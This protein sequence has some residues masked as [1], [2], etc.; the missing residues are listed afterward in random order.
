MKPLIAIASVVLLI[1]VFAVWLKRQALDTDRWTQTSADLLADED[2]QIAV[3]DFL[4]DRITVNL[5]AD[6]VRRLGGGLRD[7]AQEALADPA[8]S[9]AWEEANRRVHM[10]VLAIIDGEEVAA[11]DAT[12]ELDPVLAEITSQLGIGPQ[13]AARLPDRVARLKILSEDELESA[14]TGARLLRGLA[15]PLLALAI[16]LYA[17]AI[18]AARGRRR[19]AV[20]LCGLSF[21]LVAAV[22]LLVRWLGGAIASAALSD[23]VSADDAVGAIWSITTSPLATSAYVLAAIGV[24]TLVVALVLGRFSREPEP[25]YYG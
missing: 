1:S 24:A 8:V 19:E 18:F 9:D 13:L 21:V 6:V 15:Y 5:G 11:G 12:L 3:A 22:I 14:Q 25:A 16:A 2:V 7:T 10:Q 4:V 17:A 23:T 20:G